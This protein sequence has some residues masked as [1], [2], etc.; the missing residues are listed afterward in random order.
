MTARL[1][2]DH[3]AVNLLGTFYIARAAA[4]HMMER[5]GGTIVNVGSELSHIGMPLY[6]P[7]CASK[8][9]VIGLTK[10]MAAEL[11]PKVTVNAICPGP[12]D[13]PMMEAE[14]QWFGGTDKVRRDV[15]ERVPL[16]RLASPEEVAVAILFLAADAPFATGATLALDGG[17]TAV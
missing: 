17:T 7:Y 15:T 12:V 2:A 10:S 14:I 11:A 4:L 16:K 5:D 3:I 6:V 13:T 9:G 1:F 8:A